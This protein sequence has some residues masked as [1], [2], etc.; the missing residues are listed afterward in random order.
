M[1]VGSRLAHHTQVQVISCHRTDKA[2]SYRYKMKIILVIVS[3]ILVRT[4]TC[5]AY[6]CEDDSNFRFKDKVSK[7]CNWVSEYPLRRCKRKDSKKDPNTERIV[8]ENYCKQTCGLCAVLQDPV[9]APVQAPVRAPV[10]KDDESYIFN[11]KQWKNCGLWVRRDLAKRCNQTDKGGVV[12]KDK[13]RSACRSECQDEFHIL[14]FPQPPRDKKDQIGIPVP[15]EP[16]DK[17]DIGKRY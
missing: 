17:K 13:C 5:S 2:P 15:Q 4:R 16:R 14:P 6:A 7:D 1:Y 3:F 10:C 8:V 12:V 11:D 9:Q